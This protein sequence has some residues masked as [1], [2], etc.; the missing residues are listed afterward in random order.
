[1]APDF[2][3]MSTGKP[4]A[5]PSDNAAC[6]TVED[7][8]PCRGIVKR[9]LDCLKSAL[10]AE[11]PALA[12]L[13]GSLIRVQRFLRLFLTE[14]SRRTPKFLPESSSHRAC[15]AIAAPCR[16]FRDRHARSFQKPLSFLL[17]A[18]VA[19]NG[20]AILP[21]YVCA[22]YLSTGSLVEILPQWS[23]PAHQ[24][25]MVSPEGRT[26]SKAQA[27]FRGYVDSYDFGCL[28]S[29]ARISE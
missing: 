3:S 23:I 9:N 6:N 5:T 1:M 11:D 29:G 17:R 22:P 27:A 15:V 16:D 20:L 28:S 7:R 8:K 13:T 26:L 24:M 21:A 4:L 14:T 2:F 12:R 25:I 19:G 10:D 18:S